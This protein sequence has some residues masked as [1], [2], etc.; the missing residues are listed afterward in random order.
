MAAK[1]QIKQLDVEY[2]QQDVPDWNEMPITV[3]TMANLAARQIKRQSK[4]YQED[5]G[6]EKEDRVHATPQLISS[7]VLLCVYPARV[8]R[9]RRFQTSVQTG[10]V[11][12]AVPPVWYSFMVQF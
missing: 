10:T 4:Q 12:S 6:E 8:V 3:L 1:R 5:V 2:Q 7:T 11:G 9:L